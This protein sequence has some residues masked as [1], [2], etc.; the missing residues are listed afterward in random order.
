[1]TTIIMHHAI[2]IGITFVVSSNIVACTVYILD[3]VHRVSWLLYTLSQPL[4]KAVWGRCSEERKESYLAFA[5]K[6]AKHSLGS[7]LSSVSFRCASSKDTG[8][9]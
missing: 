7:G 6:S 3:N 1:M 5:Y 8:R 2:A 4:C 9:L